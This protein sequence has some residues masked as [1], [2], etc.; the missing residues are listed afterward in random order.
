MATIWAVPVVDYFY[1]SVLLNPELPQDD[2]VHTTHGV[3]P[4][5]GLLMPGTQPQSHR[6][7]KQTGLNRLG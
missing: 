1:C 3:R 2:V 5:V 7:A 4:G 6:L